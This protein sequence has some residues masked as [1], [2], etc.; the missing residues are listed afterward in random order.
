MRAK[1]PTTR[2][3][4]LGLGWLLLVLVPVLGPLP[5]PGGV[6]LLAG[7]LILL[8]RNSVWARRRYVRAKRRWPRFGNMADRAMRRPSALRRRALGGD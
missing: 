5:G 8:L 2:L 7:G 1:S 4:L 6:F 3:L